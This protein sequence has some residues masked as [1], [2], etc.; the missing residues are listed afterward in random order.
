MH[1]VMG[2]HIV[3]ALMGYAEL[4][5]RISSADIEMTYMWYTA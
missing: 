5:A 1:V 4:L 3:Q 2:D